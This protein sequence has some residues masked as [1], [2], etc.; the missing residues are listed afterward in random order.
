MKRIYIS[1]PITKGDRV[2]HFARFA[3]A[4]CRLLRLGFAPLNP[5]LSMLNPATW[6]IAHRTWLAADKAWIEVADAVLRLPGESIGAMEELER[7]GECDIPV[8]YS[9]QS[10]VAHFAAYDPDGHAG[11]PGAYCEP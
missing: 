6:Q 7:A 10:I 8:F 3:D 4:Q 5:G 2:A 11:E 1:G 9:I